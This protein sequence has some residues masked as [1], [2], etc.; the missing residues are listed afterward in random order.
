MERPVTPRR[1]VVAVFAISGV[2][3]ERDPLTLLH[4]LPQTGNLA[5]APLNDYVHYCSILSLSYDL[6]LCPNSLKIEKSYLM[7]R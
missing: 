5:G 3:C 6:Q 4:L 2:C 7:S 1:L